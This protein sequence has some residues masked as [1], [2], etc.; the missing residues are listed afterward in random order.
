MI[1]EM[2]KDGVIKFPK[3]LCP[4][5]INLVKEED[6][7]LK[8]YVRFRKLKPL[9]TN[10][11]FPYMSDA[12]DSLRETWWPLLIPD[13]VLTFSHRNTPYLSKSYYD[14]CK[15]NLISILGR[16]READLR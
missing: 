6:D 14:I 7:N 3:L 15:D 5:S 16:P 2:L 11:V 10:N 9:A 12:L 13:D 8:L 1:G 4:Q